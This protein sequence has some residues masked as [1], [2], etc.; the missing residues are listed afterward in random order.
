MEFTNGRNGRPYDL[1]RAKVWF[2]KAAT[3]GYAPAMFQ[4]SAIASSADER[5]KWLFNAANAGSGEAM[6][7]I[8]FAYLNGAGEYQLL[9]DSQAGLEWARHAKRTDPQKYTRILSIAEKQIAEE[10]R[11][12]AL[13]EQ[14]ERNKIREEKRQREQDLED[15]LQKL[16]DDYNAQIAG[17][18][19]ARQ[20]A[21]AEAEAEARADAEAQRWNDIVNHIQD[22]G[23]EITH[24]L[25]H[26]Q[27]DTQRAF[28]HS[29]RVQRRNERIAREEYERKKK[30]LKEEA[31]RNRQ[32]Y[33]DLE[34]KKAQQRQELE[35]QKKASRKANPSQVPFVGQGTSHIPKTVNWQVAPANAAGSK[36]DRPSGNS[37]ITHSS[38]LDYVLDT[39]LHGEVHDE[40]RKQEIERQKRAK[41]A[42]NT[43]SPQRT[44]NPPPHAGII[45]PAPPATIAKKSVVTGTSLSNTP[46]AGGWINLTVAREKKEIAESK[47]GMMWWSTLP[48]SSI[49]AIARCEKRGERNS[50][51]K[52]VI[53]NDYNTTVT[54][55]VELTIQS[56]GL[57]ENVPAWIAIL[58]PGEERRVA[59]RYIKDLTCM[60]ASLMM[61]RITSM[62][63]REDKGKY[64]SPTR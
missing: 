42:S 27:Q 53:K 28:E 37:P 26:V 63:F 44:S 35:R 59:S 43:G 47:S 54:V 51:W 13:R 16:E 61:M 33:E 10:N 31:R 14:S 52:F 25:Y 4:L 23:D 1:R 46:V 29:Q 57:S 17:Q 3:L 60:D 34:R 2:M 30:K 56:S 38:D 5:R 12:Q 8:A 32:R 6:A 50:S 24:D 9:K 18:E 49:A 41:S 15:Q 62:K 40:L 21:I 19:K 20:K 55:Q 11:Q 22:V 36:T 7:T 45:N 48:I 58:K 39:S 64:A